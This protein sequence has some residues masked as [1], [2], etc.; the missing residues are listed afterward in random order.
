MCQGRMNVN[1]ILYNYA[2]FMLVLCNRYCI[3]RA[4]H[5]DYSHTSPTYI[6]IYYKPL[7]KH[8]K[9]DNV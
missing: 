9:I 4:R 3:K 2:K 5:V 8:R 1:H 7:T 6:Q